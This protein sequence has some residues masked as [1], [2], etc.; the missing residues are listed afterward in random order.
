MELRSR[1][2]KNKENLRVFCIQHRNI[3]LLLAI[4]IL[5][6]FAASIF[7][8]SKFGEQTLFFENE[9]AHSYVDLGKSLSEGKGFVR[10]GEASAYR[11]PL[12]PL[13]LSILFITKLPFTWAVLMFQNI[14]AS[15]GGVLLY[16]IGK[17]IFSGRVGLLVFC[18]Y[19]IEPYLLLTS[20]LATTETVFIFLTILI[21]YF[22]VRFIEKNELKDI[23]LTAALCGLATLTRPVAYYLPLIVGIVSIL[24]VG[25]LKKQW[26]RAGIVCGIIVLVYCAVLSPWLVRQYVQ[27]KTTH[28][29]NIDAFMLYA[30]V[31]PIVEMDRTGL[32]YE[33]AAKSVIR[34]LEEKPGYSYGAIINR[35]DYYDFMKEETRQMV[36]SDPIPV[37]RFYAVSS[38]PTLFG[39]GYEYIL[40]NVF[41]VERT[42]SRVSY[43]E[44]LLKEGITGVAH[45]FSNLD[46]FQV[47]LLLSVLMW[48]VIYISIMMLVVRKRSWQQHGIYLLFFILIAG[49]FTF[50]TLGPASQV[51]YRLPSF[52]FLYLLLAAAVEAGMS[53]NI[54]NIK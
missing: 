34:R 15:L 20:N 24:S 7:L 32:N 22:F 6:H 25:C 14:I 28:I 45:I 39:T 44:V 47:I 17:K 37:I 1:Y 18:L 42:L 46:I 52:P 30:R 9:D 19:T 2:V 10:E 36:M 21:A 26:K 31:A 29:T 27:F 33:E 40:E 38:I 50:F 3:F 13:I 43:T 16:V 49:Y 4:G 53:R 35:F 8:Y 11:T 23:I 12:Y 41:G 51:R 54:R 48:T 5:V